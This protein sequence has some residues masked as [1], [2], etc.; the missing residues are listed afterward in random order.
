MAAADPAGT[1]GD[2][3]RAAVT[4]AAAA[5]LADHGLEGMRGSGVGEAAGVSEATVWFHFGT[6]A[7]LLVAVMED[8][9][10][11]LVAAVDEVVAAAHAPRA[12]L[13]A[14]TRF[15]LER[16]T[17]DLALVAEFQ[18]HGRSGHDPEVVRAFAACN[19]RVTRQFERLVED[20]VATG[21]VRS[22][23]PTWMVRD[24]FFGTAEHVLVGRAV[25]GRS[26]DLDAAA[27]L[28]LDV[29]LHGVG[30]QTTA[31]RDGRDDLAAIEAKLDVLLARTDEQ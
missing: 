31:G 24:V 2:R 8:Y 25:T 4:T 29:V 17:R 14:F 15:W 5:Q 30:D 26:T 28:L 20:L 9:Y 6:K 23:L 1:R 16:M 12:R 21:E 27:D 13:E 10:D 11:R 7:G 3:T 18:R 19:R 22:D